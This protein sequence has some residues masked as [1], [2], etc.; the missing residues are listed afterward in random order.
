LTYYYNKII[1]Y[2]YVYTGP[3][4]DIKFYINAIDNL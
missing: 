1:F 2:M 3:D 4:L